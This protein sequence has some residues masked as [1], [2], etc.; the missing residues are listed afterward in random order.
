VIDAYVHVVILSDQIVIYRLAELA[1][2]QYWTSSDCVAYYSFA[3]RVLNG[4]NQQRLKP[5]LMHQYCLLALLSALVMY[6]A[7]GLHSCPATM[8]AML[9]EKPECGC[10]QVI[11]NLY[12]C[13]LVHHHQTNIADCTL[14]LSRQ[15][16]STGKPKCPAFV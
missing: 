11:M 4:H 7:A 9:S 5:L 12:H 6:W 15:T 1:L 13:V 10:S 2:C 3:R 14:S 16:R 8:Q